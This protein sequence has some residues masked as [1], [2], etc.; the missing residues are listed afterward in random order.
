MLSI[1]EKIKGYSFQDERTKRLVERLPKKSIAVIVHQDI[2]MAA[3]EKLISCK[4]KAVINLKTSMSGL[5]SHKGVEVLLDSKIAVFDVEGQLELNLEG[6][7]LLITNGHLFQ[8]VDGVW[9]FVCKV[10]RYS[11]A[12]VQQLRIVANSNFPKQFKD[13][14]GNSLYYGEK[15]LDLFVKEVQKL[16]VLRQFLGKEVLIVARGPNYEKDL[17]LLKPFI[18]KKKFLII[19]VDGGADGLLKIGIK[20]DFIVGDMDSVSEKSLKSGAQLLVHTYRDGRSPGEQRIN[21]L[22]LSFKRI[23]L[24]GTSEDVAT[25]FA[26]CSGAKRL[27]TVGTRLGMNEFLEKGRIGMGSSLL[28]RMKVSHVLVD[29]KGF[30]SLFNEEKEKEKELGGWK[31]IPAA[32]TIG[33]LVVSDRFDLFI[34]LVFQWWGGR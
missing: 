11:Y 13:F 5:F 1:D 22:G 12:Q 7:L 32:I 29:L 14:V 6:K 33:L 15:E 34:A 30:H 8:D 24:L 18:K 16:P 9:E 3:A 19:A 23:S 28:T 31:L 17:L 26:Y 10:S 4:V 20:P 27:Y 2:D 21:S 25:I